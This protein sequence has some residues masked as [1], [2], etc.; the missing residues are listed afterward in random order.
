MFYLRSWRLLPQCNAR[1]HSE[2]CRRARDLHPCSSLSSPRDYIIHFIGGCLPVVVRLENYSMSMDSVC[3]A[4][5]T[6][7]SISQQIRGPYCICRQY[8]LH[9]GL[10]LEVEA[11]KN[12]RL[13]DGV[14]FALC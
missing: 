11:P 14:I 12:S 3:V 13:G 5:A 4:K 6:I 8:V 7:Q 10:D 9:D 2:L 1:I